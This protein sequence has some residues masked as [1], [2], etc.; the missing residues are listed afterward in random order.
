MNKNKLFLATFLVATFLVLPT[1]AVPSTTTSERND[2]DCTRAFNDCRSFSSV[3]EAGCLAGGGDPEFCLYAASAIFCSC[4]NSVSC[5]TPGC[6]VS[7]A[8]PKEDKE[9]MRSVHATLVTK[10][11]LSNEQQDRFKHIIDELIAEQHKT[12]VPSK[13]AI[14][15]MRK[16][17]TD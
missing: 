1:L 17:L 15:A 5:V 7:Q 9:F 3:Y 16:L 6:I 4:M 12:G 8:M 2:E 14:D 13:D 11:Q 10:K